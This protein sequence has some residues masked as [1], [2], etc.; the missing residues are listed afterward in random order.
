MNRLLHSKKGQLFVIESFIAV[1]VMII[2]VT[3]L[4]Q[5]QVSTTPTPKP[6]YASSIDAVME[7]LDKNG[8]LDEL[9]SAIISNQ[10]NR[11]AAAKNS[12]T[13]AIYATL[14]DNGDFVMYCTNVTSGSIISESWIHEKLTIPSDAIGI[15]Y[16]I[17][18][19]NGNFAPYVFHVY[20][21]IKGV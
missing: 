20:A 15:D 19:V 11:I 5:V 8:E 9:I 18:E 2:M 6:D 3:A 14:P 21:W 7:S 13:N 17:L 10:A 4:Y 16:L 12:I 1:S